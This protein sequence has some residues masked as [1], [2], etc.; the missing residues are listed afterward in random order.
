[1]GTQLSA[2]AIVERWRRRLP[3]VRV[4]AVI[5][6]AIAAGVVAWLLVRG[7]GDEAPPT[8]APAR[9]AGPVM[10]TLSA[11]RARAAAADQPVY[12]AGPL[13]G[14]RFE[15]TETRGRIYVRYLPAG[16]AV[17]SVKPYL[18]VATYRHANAF[19]ATNTVAGGAGAVRI[20]VGGRG[21]A[22]FNRSRPT[23][24]YLAY[25]GSPYQ[26]EVFHP[27]ARVA[28]ELVASRRVRPI[29]ARG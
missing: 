22:F 3:N 18:T 9:S 6:I 26:I 25:R 1:V 29:P 27:V 2:H 28:R 10:V 16:A 17:G 14:R 5:A 15:L 7:D 12:W 11:L 23:S 4:G 21:V 13:R 8:P 20:D 19:D 24:V